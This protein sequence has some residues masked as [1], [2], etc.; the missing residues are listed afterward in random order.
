MFNLN[1]YRRQADRIAD[2]LPW[3]A[4]VAPGVILN[5]DGSFQRTISFRGP[6]LESASDSQLVSAC[7]RLNNCLKRLGSGWAIYIEAR[8]HTCQAYPD[9]KQN[10]FPEPLSLLIDTERREAFSAMETNFESDFFLT[11]QYLPSPERSQKVKQFFIQSEGEASDH[12]YHDDQTYFIQMTERLGDMLKDFMYEAEFLTDEQTLKYLHSIVSNRDHPIKPPEIPAY[13]DAY[14]ADT[15][16]VGGLSPKLGER[17]LAVLSVLNFPSTTFPTILE[18]LNHLPLTYRWVTRFIPLDKAEAER[19]LKAY[20]RRW[21]AKRKGMLN[22][23]QEVFTKQESQ[24]Q[25]TAAVEKA[26]DATEALSS[27]ANQY[28]AYGYYTA[29]VTVTGATEAEAQDALRQVERVI[30][31]MGF[32]TISETVNSVEAWLSSLPGHAYA[33]VRKPLLHSLNLCH[34]IPL[35]AVWSGQHE[36]EHLAAP[37]LVVCA[38]SWAYAISFSQ[39]YW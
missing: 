8:R 19:E 11:F 2:V 29:T 27:L 24:L 6:D 39:S 10:H 31:G 33:N 12:D 17:Y 28:V 22:M 37:P 4:L 1:E 3:V 13:L 26:Q 36:D 18:Q 15:P 5:K 21:F 35:S 25:D 23:L 14:L 9:P 7:A 34:L 32:T 20:K 16:L 38:Y 30:N